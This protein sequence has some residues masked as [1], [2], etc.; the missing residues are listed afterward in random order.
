MENS[1]LH[2]KKLKLYEKRKILLL[3]AAVHRRFQNKCFKI[4][5]NLQKNTNTGVS[6][7]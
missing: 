2:S 1:R 7:Q 5:Q 4:S 3:K 6:L